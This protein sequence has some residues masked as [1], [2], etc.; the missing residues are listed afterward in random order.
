MLLINSSVLSSDSTEK[1][2][3]SWAAVLCL[4]S[5]GITFVLLLRKNNH[6]N[7]QIRLNREL[8]SRR[9]FFSLVS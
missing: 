9:I 2:L 5:A 1:K 7:F 6:H 3:D 8:N 4:T